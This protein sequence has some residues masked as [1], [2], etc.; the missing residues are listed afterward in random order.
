M[1]PQH[2]QSSAQQSMCV[3]VLRELAGAEADEEEAR[4]VSERVHRVVDS[5]EHGHGLEG[6]HGAREEGCLPPWWEAKPVLKQAKPCGAQILRLGAR[7]S[8]C[9]MLLTAPWSRDRGRGSTPQPNC[10]FH[11]CQWRPCQNFC[12]SD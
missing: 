1:F 3:Y 9:A 4:R 8:Y 12:S 7:R 5:L 2:D 6:P 11:M 10:S